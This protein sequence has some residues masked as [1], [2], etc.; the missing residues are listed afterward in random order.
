M[1]HKGRFTQLSWQGRLA[2]RPWAPLLLHPGC[3]P[4]CPRSGWL[5]RFSDP[6]PRP[7][8]WQEAPSSNGPGTEGHGRRVALCLEDAAG[9]VPQGAALGPV[10]LHIVI[11]DPKAL[12]KGT[13][14]KS[15]DYMKWRWPFNMP[16]GR[17]AIQR[18]LRLEGWTNRDLVQ[19]SKD[20][21]CP[22]EGEVS[23][24]DKGWGRDQRGSNS[25][26]PGSWAGA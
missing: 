5:C 19:F 21:L 17:A 20:R 26:G 12:T 11:D 9:Q 16:N 7:L 25:G 24:N 8:R 18:D 2:H 23:R 14:V 6:A 22:W 15:A 3:V 10:L 4:T 1:L 13:L